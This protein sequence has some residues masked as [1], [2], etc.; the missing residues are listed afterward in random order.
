MIF[1]AHFSMWEGAHFFARVWLKNSGTRGCVG[2][3]NWDFWERHRLACP[4][5]QPRS[6]VRLGSKAVQSWVKPE[7]DP[8]K[9]SA[10]LI[11]LRRNRSSDGRC[12]S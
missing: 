9:V 3:W 2:A 4:K 12:G 5:F 7:V 10:L 1:D 8:P 6:G 11:G